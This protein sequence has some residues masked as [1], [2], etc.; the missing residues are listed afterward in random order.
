MAFS[1]E[2][3]SRNPYPKPFHGPLTQALSPGRGRGGRSRHN[4]ESHS[5]SPLRSV[6]SGRTDGALTVG[7][8]SA[9]ESPVGSG[10]GR[11]W[12]ARSVPPTATRAHPSVAFEL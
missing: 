1:A 4:C 7:G 9:T 6:I 5:L 2:L 12:A 11:R 3:F 10:T 8:A